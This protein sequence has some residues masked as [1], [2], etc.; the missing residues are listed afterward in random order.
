[1]QLYTATLQQ[2]KLPLPKKPSIPAVLANTLLQD[3]FTAGMQRLKAWT[4]TDIALP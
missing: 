1:M 4:E 3:V 2:D